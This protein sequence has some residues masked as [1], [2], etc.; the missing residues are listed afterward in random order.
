MDTSDYDNLNDH[1]VELISLDEIPE[2]QTQ[3]AIPSGG[4]FVRSQLAPRFNRRTRILQ[5]T[6]L[7]IFTLI[8]LLTL[9]FGYAPTR[10]IVLNAA[11]SLFPTPTATLAPGTNSFYLDASPGWGQLF[12]DSR[13]INPL[14][15]YGTGNTLIL[16]N[17]IHSI[18]W[19][20]PPFEDQHCT[21]SIPP[22]LAHD[23]CQY[24]QGIDNTEGHSSWLLTFSV[25][26]A[27]LSPSQRM[28]LTQ[29]MQAAL[30]AQ[31]A[32]TIVQPGESY[33]VSRSYAASMYGNAQPDVKTAQP[34]RATLHF[35]LD[36][37]I[38]SQAHCID[39]IFEEQAQSGC[40]FDGQNCLLLCSFP[41]YE[42]NLAYPASQWVTYGMV[43][44][45]WDYSTLNG[46]LVATNQP[47]LD[48]PGA[49]QDEHRLPF[50]ISWSGNRWHATTAF[51]QKG[52]L[53]AGPNPFCYPAQDEFFQYNMIH[54]LTENI[55]GM[56]AYT[57]NYQA[58]LNPA[59]GCI[60]TLNLGQ[61]TSPGI[62]EP[63]TVGTPK[64]LERFGVFVA[65]NSAAHKLWPPPALPMADAYEQQLAQ[66]VA[67]TTNQPG[68]L[69]VK[70]SG[71]VVK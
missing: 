45:S 44:S 28:A 56:L 19:H 39:D 54:M 27:Q 47:D 23:T 60:V 71:E 9:L 8:L 66:Q 38:N 31:Q 26:L 50:N 41:A 68:N 37:N 15:T 59:D 63:T 55:Q 30:D 22:N 5:T 4:R 14:P 11:G 70:Y 52:L 24:N 53:P 10:T 33:A 46:Q 16:T 20:A 67:S 25:S 35:Q 49:T 69:A 29:A 6:A 17:G 64:Y 36:T 48:A 12:V 3:T 40:W 57:L 21:I 7:A 62:P 43:R 1:D 42:Q 2:K 61:D 13:R 34:L 51:S 58:T 32:T 18:I 65:L